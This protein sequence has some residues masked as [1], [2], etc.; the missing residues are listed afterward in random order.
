[1]T[2]TDFVLQS[3]SSNYN[4]WNNY[5]N[6]YN[7]GSGYGGRAY[8]GTRYNGGINPATGGPEA[9]NIG[10]GNNL[11]AFFLVCRTCGRG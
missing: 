10:W 9:G 1:M 7:Y 6:N 3:C 8:L 2:Y 5:Y 11:A 4:N